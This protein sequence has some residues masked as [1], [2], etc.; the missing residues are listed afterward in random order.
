MPSE[1]I[2]ISVSNLTKTYRLFEHPGDRVKQFLS[3]GV[4]QYH[5][6]FTALKGLSFDIRRGETVGIIGRNGSGKS[7]LLQTICGI[8]KPTSGSVSVKGRISALLELGAGFNPE[9][10]GRE[11]IY[12]QG[13]LMGLT[14]AQM[15][16]RFDD[17]VDF[18]D[19]GEF[20]DQPVRVYSSGMFVRLAFAVAVNVAP[21]I[22][23]V[24]EALAVGDALFQM[25]CLRRIDDIRNRGG[26][27]LI[28]THAVEQVAHHC[29]RALLLGKGTLLADGDTA[30]TLSRYLDQSESEPIRAMSVGVDRETAVESNDSF[31]RH[32]AYNPDETRWGDRSA[33]IEGIQI[34]QNCTENPES[35]LPGVAIEVRLRIHYHADI[36]RPIY[37]LAIKTSEGAVVF[38]TNSRVL[39]G[40]SG[41]ESRSAGDSV[42]A[43]FRLNPCV[44]SGKYSLSVGVASEGSEGIVP[45]DRRFDSVFIQFAHAITSAGEIE[46][47]PS[48]ERF[49]AK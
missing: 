46:M 41:F 48:F 15:D 36:E 17:I 39:L 32:P 27:I 9:F 37:G 8:L 40:N 16:Q 1:D 19:I 13:T 28:V 11:N 23:V 33:T 29:D 3:L 35:L 38:T 18:A 44:D 25:K 21:D 22:L 24:D 43:R 47:S 49:D 6:E 34:V 14:K 20:L 10:T 30:T 4:K 45:H 31:L 7:T 42:H 26:T 2:V 12:F 5:R